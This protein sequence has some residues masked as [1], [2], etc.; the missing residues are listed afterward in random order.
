MKEREVERQEKRNEKNKGKQKRSSEQGENQKLKY[1][2]KE[3]NYKKNGREVADHVDPAAP[4]K[5]AFV[6]VFYELFCC[7]LSL[8]PSST[9]S[10]DD[11]FIVFLSMEPGDSELSHTLFK[12]VRLAGNF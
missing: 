11:I 12:C 3:R 1:R 4:D 8:R 6:V 5:T 9:L 10:E 2:K 7:P